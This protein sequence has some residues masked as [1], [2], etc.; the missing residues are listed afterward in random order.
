[1]T[2]GNSLLFEFDVDEKSS[3]LT[4]LEHVVLRVSVELGGASRLYSYID[5]I[6]IESG[7]NQ[8]LLK[9]LTQHR[10]VRRGDVTITLQ[11]PFGTVSHLLPHRPQ[12]FINNIGF[13]QWPLMSVHHW[14]ESPQGRWIV[15]ISHVSHRDSPAHTNGYALVT[16][17]ELEL[18]GTLQRPQAVDNIP[19]RCSELCEDRG[20]CGGVGANMCDRC[21]FLRHA[22]TL[23]CVD[24]CLSSEQAYEGYCIPSKHSTPPNNFNSE[25]SSV[26]DG[27]TMFLSQGLSAVMILA[28][29]SVF[30]I[31]CH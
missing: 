28:Y 18:F 7:G 20:K 31:N 9:Q 27:G 4:F 2:I 11:S 19:K 15:N 24:S 10:D 22:S 26:P 12:D 5:Y 13:E 21:Q 8:T 23:K 25:I 1:M 14:A 29:L 17:L 6:T 30:I 16:G 3:R